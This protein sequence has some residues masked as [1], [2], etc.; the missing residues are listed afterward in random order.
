MRQV[1]IALIGLGTVG[2]GV[3]KTLEIQK[4][5]IEHKEN[6][7]LNLKKVLA[8]EY[9]IDIP[10]ELKARD[11]YKDIIE[12]ESIE[13][14]IELIGGI[15]PAREFILAALNAGKTVIT[16]NKDLLSQHWPALN[17]AASKSGA[18]LYFEASVGGGIP[19]LRTIWE[20]LQA[21]EITS[22]MGIING[23]T[24]Y[25]LTRMTEDK[26]SYEEALAQAQAQGLAEANP[27]SDVEGYDAMYKLS[28]LSSMAFHAR[29]PIEYIYCEGITKVTQEDIAYG[30]ELGYTVK[31]LAIT[32]RKGNTIEARVHPTMIPCTHPLAS[33]RGAFNAIFLHGNIVD[34]IMLYG[35][36]AGDM[37]TAS[38]VVSDVIY[39]AEHKK[40][41]YTTFYNAENVSD[42]LAFDNDWDSEYFIRVIAQDSPGVLGK[43]ANV[44]GNHGVSLASVIQKGHDVDSVPLIFITHKA[45]ELSFKKA[46]EE[47][48][49]IDEVITVA[50]TIRVER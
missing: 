41:R 40:H 21:N 45:K 42:E 26:L 23:T 49:N 34:D 16:A 5:R 11:Y 31:L 39:A 33:V 47:I 44:F 15:N 35:R 14:V 1:N 36:G 50:N 6:I 12:D 7:S 28:I 30:K 25:I 18:G 32:K 13:I 43:I 19:I 22:L 24:N 46:I 3:Y 37:P 4:K 20:S 27:K 9:S 8:L 17:A 29:V 48:S 2:S 10:E 38:A